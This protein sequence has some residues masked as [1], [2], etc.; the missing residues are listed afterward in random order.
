MGLCFLLRDCSFS[1]FLYP[2]YWSEKQSQQAVCV[3][4]QELAHMMVVLASL[5]SLGQ[6]HRSEMQKRGPVLLSP[7]LT[8][9]QSS[10]SID[11]S[12]FFSSSGL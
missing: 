6:A 5:K 2:V 4:A 9:T 7:K 10:L 8:Y 12:S 11:S 1:E 3:A